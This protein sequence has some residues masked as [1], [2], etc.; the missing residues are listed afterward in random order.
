LLGNAWLEHGID[1][2]LRLLRLLLLLSLLRLLLLLVTL[3]LNLSMRS[4]ISCELGRKFHDL[5]GNLLILL[6]NGLGQ[7]VEFSEPCLVLLL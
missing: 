6:L 5:V 4:L 1:R 7:V 3:L 2:L